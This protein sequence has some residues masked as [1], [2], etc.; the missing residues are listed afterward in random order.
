MAWS[1]ILRALR[2]GPGAEKP[3]LLSEETIRSLVQK[4]DTAAQ[5]RL[6]RGLAL[7]HVDS[8]SCGGCEIAL[9]AT[10]NALH[11][12]ERYGLHFVASPRAADVLIVT[13]PLTRN[14][15]EALLLTWEATP[16]PK[17][18]IGI[19]DCA[20]DG[21]VFKGSY[22]VEGGIAAALPVDLMIPGCPPTPAQILSGLRALLE[23]N[24][25]K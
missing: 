25:R 15:R 17:W 12:L 6:G 4:L 11:D 10:A 20:V 5:T 7:R 8:G 23:A 22:A 21:G 16:D 2:D 19:G 14:L 9:R 1:H 3:P 13:G 24:A 18:V